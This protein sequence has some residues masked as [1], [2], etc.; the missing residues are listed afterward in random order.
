MLVSN[1][2][3]VFLY[4]K[5]VSSFYSFS[6]DERPG[7]QWIK[8]TRKFGDKEDIKL[9]ATMFEASVPVPKPGGVTTEDDI[10][11]HTTLIVDIFK[12]E[13]TDVLEFICS[14]WPES[15][16][17]QKVYLCGCD[18]IASQ[19]YMGPSFTELDDDLQ[20]SLYD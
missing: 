9:E 7:E 14:A 11:L 8:L 6:I 3:N 18:Q 15:V 16:Q 10:K 4:G 5:P 13:E 2:N 17:I 19:A 20:V 12:G 1:K